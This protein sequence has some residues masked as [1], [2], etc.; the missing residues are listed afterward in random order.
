MH[1]TQGP[2]A[3]REGIHRYIV[4]YRKLG[5]E[6]WVTALDRSLKLDVMAM[7]QIMAKVGNLHIPDTGVL[8]ARDKLVR[9]HD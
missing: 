2:N 9:K 5:E 8:E 3:L 4:K 7:Q 6:N 1:P